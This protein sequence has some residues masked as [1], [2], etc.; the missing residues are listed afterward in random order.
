[1]LALASGVAALLLEVSTVFGLTVL[2]F[3]LLFSGDLTLTI[4]RNWKSLR[5]LKKAAAELNGETSSQGDRIASG[6]ANS[7]TA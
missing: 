5:D 2:C 7:T 6:N 1:M 3:G 4:F